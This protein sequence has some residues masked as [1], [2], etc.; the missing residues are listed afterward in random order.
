VAVAC[1]GEDVTSGD[2]GSLTRGLS[3][4]CQRPMATSGILAPCRGG[5]EAGI[6]V[7]AGQV[8]A[9]EAGPRR[10]HSSRAVR[11]LSDLISSDVD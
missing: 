3:S 9:G 2:V 8:Q 6:V 4:T 10:C 11:R 1:R 7:P 5:E